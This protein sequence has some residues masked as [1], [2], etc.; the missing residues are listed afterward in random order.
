MSRPESEPPETRE[1]QCPACQSEEIM[2]V[3]HVLAGDE[4]IKVEHRCESC[5]VTFF[6]VRKPLSPEPS[7]T[8]VDQGALSATGRIRPRV[9][10]MDAPASLSA[11]VVRTPLPA[12]PHVSMLGQTADTHA[13]VLGPPAENPA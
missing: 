3:G 8:M 12:P 1:R 11:R 2:R 13:V 9:C 6:F 10:V 7:Q 5:G 4:I